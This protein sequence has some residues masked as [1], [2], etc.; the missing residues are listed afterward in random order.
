[1]NLSRNLTFSFAKSCWLN[2]TELFIHPRR[3]V[4]KNTAMNITRRNKL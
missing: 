3:R 1:M 4:A 2:I